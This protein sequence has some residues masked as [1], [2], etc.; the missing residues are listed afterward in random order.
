[1]LA[2][3]PARR[4]PEVG[5]HGLVHGPGRVDLPLEA[6]ARHVGR[7]DHDG[8][9]GGEQSNVRARLAGI[10][11]EGEP[12]A[13][14][15]EREGRC[16]EHLTPAGVEEHARPCVQGLR[17]EHPTGGMGSVVGQRHV[18]GQDLAAFEQLRIGH[19][20]LVLVEQEG[21]AREHGMTEGPQVPDRPPTGL[22]E[23]DDAEGRRGTH[24]THGLE[25]EHRRGQPLGDRLRVAPGRTGDRDAPRREQL[26]VEVVDAGAGG[27]HEAGPRIAQQV[28]V[29]PRRGSDRDQI[30]VLD[31]RAAPRAPLEK[32]KIPEL[33]QGIPHVGDRAVRQDPLHEV[34]LVR[35]GGDP[36]L[37]PFDKPHV[38]TLSCLR[39]HGATPSGPG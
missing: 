32:P 1:M 31:R 12:R 17:V 10:D 13:G 9:A 39:A 3:V 26:Q 2:S 30:P 23:P 33:P 22:A 7:G 27:G 21:I 35:L 28:R 16:V 11:I 19:E 14:G 29:H 4:L 24:V 5:G 38:T 20:R 36:V 37:R 6:V 18:E 8:G 34:R 15:V 25:L